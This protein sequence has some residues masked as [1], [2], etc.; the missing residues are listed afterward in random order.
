MPLCSS[1]CAIGRVLARPDQQQVLRQLVHGARSSDGDKEPVEFR[2]TSEELYIW[3]AMSR[4]EGV[5]RLF[6]QMNFRADAC[7]WPKERDLQ[8]RT[9]FMINPSRFFPRRD[10]QHWA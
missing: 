6:A 5:L 10:A 7:A 4:V 1:N 8:A 3:G 9:L 2:A